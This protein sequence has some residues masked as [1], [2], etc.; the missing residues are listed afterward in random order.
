MYSERREQEADGTRGSRKASE[1][2]GGSMGHKFRDLYI[3]PGCQED[4]IDDQPEHVAKLF[5]KIS[6]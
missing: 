6:P 1:I 5:N 3:S 2:T 4:Q